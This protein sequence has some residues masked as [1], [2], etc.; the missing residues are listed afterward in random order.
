MPKK[1]YFTNYV[2]DHYYCFNLAGVQELAKAPGVH[3]GHQ[4]RARNKIQRLYFCLKF[5]F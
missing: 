1:I 5:C 2:T 4:I 3:G